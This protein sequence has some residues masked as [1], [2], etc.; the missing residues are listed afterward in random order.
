M[1]NL[2]QCLVAMATAGTALAASSYVT[3]EV[4]N[5]GVPAGQLKN[6][7]GIEIYHSY[8]PNSNTSAKAI[9][10]L[11]DIFGLPLLQN[12]LLADS[13][14]SNGYLV[15]VPDLFAGDPVGV[16][17]QEAGLNLTEWRALH[18]QSAI[19]AVINS[20]IQ[21]ARNELGIEKLGGVGYCFGGKYVGR[22]L[23][24]DDSGLDV[25]FVAHPSNL[26]E[27]EIQAIAGPLSIAAG[28]EFIVSIYLRLEYVGK[29]TRTA[30]DASFNATA[31]SRAESILN[32]NNITFQTNLYSQAPHGFAVRPNLTIPQQAYAKQA[33]LVQAVTWFDAWL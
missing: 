16:E 25:G 33:S 29:L 10:H 8:P 4:R 18:P 20:T 12:K 17:E 23:K 1:I 7:S 9:I 27:T 22:W 5:A 13:I 28:S 3:L 21:Y 24:G 6:V 15:L 11:T 14:A 32:A 26:L 31:K 19:E 30:L 2:R